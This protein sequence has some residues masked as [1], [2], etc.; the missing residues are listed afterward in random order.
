MS[1]IKQPLDHPSSNKSSA[2]G[3]QNFQYFH[4]LLFDEGL[5]FGLFIANGI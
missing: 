4:S 3:N 2:T 5:L 1:I